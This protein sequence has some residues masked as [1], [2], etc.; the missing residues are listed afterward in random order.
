MWAA[1][2]AGMTGEQMKQ[3]LEQCAKKCTW[4]P[5]ISEFKELCALPPTAFPKLP[6]P[7]RARTDVQRESM[8]KIREM[9]AKGGRRPGV[10]WAEK[11]VTRHEMGDTVA[12]YALRCAQEAI[13]NKTRFDSEPI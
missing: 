9:L 13:A 3:G 7:D 1:G 2:L 11:I 6:P 4:A 5:T 12:P 10:W 8:E